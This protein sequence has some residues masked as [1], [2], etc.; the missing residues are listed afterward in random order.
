[1]KRTYL[2][3]T[4]ALLMAGLVSTSLSVATHAGIVID[5][6]TAGE[7]TD[8]TGNPTLSGFDATGSDKLVVLA[9]VGLRLAWE[10]QTGQGRFPRT[11]TL[12][13]Q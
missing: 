1:M 5:A 3:R 10:L 2:T 12:F 7:S 13:R 11:T 8:G 6:F 9:N 4:C